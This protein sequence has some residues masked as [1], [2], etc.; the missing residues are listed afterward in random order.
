MG[1]FNANNISTTF[2]DSLNTQ[3]NIGTRN[4][5]TSIIQI[6]NTNCSVYLYAPL[7]LNSI[8]YPNINSINSLGCMVVN[9]SFPVSIGTTVTPP[10][11][12]LRLTN[13][14]NLQTPAGNYLFEYK[15]GIANPTTAGY[16][17][18]SITNNVSRLDP[19]FS[20][21]FTTVISQPL[22]S[23]LTTLY[24]LTSATDLWVV[25]VAS[26]AQILTNASMTRTRIS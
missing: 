23:N 14:S 19:L 13:A 11:T 16:H 21:S 4:A 25:G 1:T 12:L 22:Y 20:V 6:G 7:M 26:T 10:T 15:F 17:T 18:I 5:N 8:V 9:S 2:I 24:S 3:L